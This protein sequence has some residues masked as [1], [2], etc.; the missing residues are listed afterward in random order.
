MT[1]TTVFADVDTGVD[2]AIALVYLL[3]SP[4]AELV[5][6]ASTGGNVGVD[7]VCEN[8]LGL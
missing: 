3:A 4:E 6:I 5:G 2:D 7:Q 1:A 8:N